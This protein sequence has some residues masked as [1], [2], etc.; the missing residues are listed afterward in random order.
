LTI[1]WL[2]CCLP[3][4]FEFRDPGLD[5]LAF[6]DQLPLPAVLDGCDS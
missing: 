4:L 1:A 5:Q 2:T 3:R 6:K